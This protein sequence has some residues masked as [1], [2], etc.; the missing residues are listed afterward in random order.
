MAKLFII[1]DLWAT[2]NKEGLRQII[3]TTILMKKPLLFLQNTV[4]R[5]LDVLVEDDLSDGTVAYEA[6]ARVLD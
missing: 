3:S 2:Y 6:G 5:S 4:P 1:S